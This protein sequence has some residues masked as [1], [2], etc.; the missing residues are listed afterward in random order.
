[1]SPAHLQRAPND[2]ARV[3]AEAGRSPLADAARATRSNIEPTPE[4][5][6]N[7]AAG[8]LEAAP[9]V[10]HTAATPEADRRAVD[11]V[12]GSAEETKQRVAQK[13]A[14]ALEMQKTAS[15]EAERRVR[16][17]EAA[18][19]E[20]KRQLE[21]QTRGRASDPR[22]RLDSRTTEPHSAVSRIQ[23]LDPH[24]RTHTSHSRRGSYP[25][26]V[27]EANGVSEEVQRRLTERMI[28]R[29]SRVIST[30]PPPPP[31]PI[32][33]HS[34]KPVSAAIFSG[35]TSVTGRIG[36]REPQR[37]DPYRRMSSANRT[38]TVHPE[39]TELA[40]PGP[41][42]RT[43][44]PEA[45]LDEDEKD[46]V[47]QSGSRPAT[48]LEKHGL[49]R[50]KTKMLTVEQ[51]LQPTIDYATEERNKCKMKAARTGLWVNLAL[52]L[53]V[54]FGALTTGLSAVLSGK[55]AGVTTTIFGGIT[56]MLASYLARMRGSGEPELSRARTKELE[57]FLRDVNAVVLDKGHHANEMKLNENGNPDPNHKDEIDLL[58]ENFR[59]RFEDIMGNGNQERK[60]ATPV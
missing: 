46:N 51:R 25:P 49:T 55:K 32:E 2:G 9:D 30:P 47:T 11:A 48:W 44:S 56:T 57:N 26:T 38:A 13:E 45:Q 52:G 31:K 43:G 53:Q 35:L 58:I 18:L 19:A 15:S 23:L 6:P 7:A 10:R 8:S 41:Q 39:Y 5:Q 20:A 42:Q 36:T 4:S 16:E 34:P 21:E 54:F 3:A 59:K 14:P 60:L 12:K 29:D 33:I 37:V 27:D 50:R 40:T 22:E 1:M 28:R 24:A 17:A